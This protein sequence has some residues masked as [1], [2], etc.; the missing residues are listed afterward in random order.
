MKKGGNRSG[1]GT[2]TR[3]EFIDF[4]DYV[5]VVVKNDSDFVRL[6]TKI[7]NVKH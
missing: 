2:V 6:C 4:M 1:G 7:W 3:E 5:S